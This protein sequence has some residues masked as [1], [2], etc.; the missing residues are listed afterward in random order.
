[1][2][3]VS[4]NEKTIICNKC[5]KI[6]SQREL[7][8]NKYHFHFEFGCKSLHNGEII[9][10]DLCSSCISEG[11]KELKLLR[12]GD[13]YIKTFKYVPEGW[14]Q[15]S[16]L[17]LNPKQ[18]QLVFDYWKLTGKWESLLPYTYQEL[19]KLNG[20]LTT[21]LINKTIKKFHPNMPLL[22][23][24]YAKLKHVDDNAI[25]FNPPEKSRIYHFPSGDVEL[26]DVTEL[27]VRD[28]GTHRLKTKD[29]KSHIV[30]AGWLHI[31]LDIKDWAV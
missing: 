7:D 10:Y 19:V 5:G 13:E 21:E 8:R 30:P 6:L 9:D 12:S 16:Y 4:D 22:E 3:I 11:T 29:G 20:Y 25:Q 24:P 15:E 28:S 18:H 1:M 17:L 26:K 14:M 27:I 31:E 2:E 23:D